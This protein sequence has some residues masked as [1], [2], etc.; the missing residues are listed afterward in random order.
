MG[1]ILLSVH[2]I[3][4]AAFWYIY[5]RVVRVSETFGLV[6]V[7]VVLVGAVFFFSVH[8]I[9]RVVGFLVPLHQCRVRIRKY[10]LVGSICGRGAYSFVIRTWYT[11]EG[12][13]MVTLLIPCTGD[14]IIHPTN[15]TYQAVVS[16]AYTRNCVREE[17]RGE[18][19]LDHLFAPEVLHILI[20]PFFL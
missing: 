6:V 11:Y 1:C 8:G 17:V 4:R 2:G 10:G 7:V 16:V 5:T 13:K 14:K 18:E 12:T 3:S 20:S 15:T 19:A 9:R